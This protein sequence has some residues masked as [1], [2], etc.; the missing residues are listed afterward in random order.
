M[1]SKRV[2]LTAEEIRRLF[3]Y[4]PETG[5]LTNRITF[6]KRISGKEAG[7]EANEIGYRS[8][9]IQKHR[10][11]VHRVIWA[12]VYGTWPST[13]LDHIDRNPRNNR[14]Q[15]LREADRSLQVRNTKIFSTNVSGIKGVSWDK[16]RN[17]WT[18]SVY[19]G[20]QRIALGRFH[21]KQDAANVRHAAMI[22]L[23]GEDLG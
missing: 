9:S 6:G 4:D 17:R 14:I 12:W 8:I 16:A 13:E 19:R 18:A 2:P 5:M 23:H 11:L 3:D 20:D 7:G 22:A 15:N 1:A 10:Y 21:N